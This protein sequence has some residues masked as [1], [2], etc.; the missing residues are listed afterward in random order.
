MTPD[1]DLPLDPS[2]RT[3]A[4]VAT[5]LVVLALLTPVG[6]AAVTY[7]GADLESGTVQQR[8]DGDTVVGIQGFHFKGQGSEK[9]PARLLSI[10]PNASFGW[11]FNGSRVGA[12][13][14]YD[15]DPLPD[16]DILVS[17]TN[18]EGTIALRIDRETRE[19]VWREEFPFE[20]THDVA[21]L[22]DGE[23]LI[24]NMRNHEDGVS[25]DRILVYNRTRGEVV[26]EWVVREHY[27]NSTAGGFNEDWTHVN[28]VDVVGD[29]LYLVSLRNFDQTI[30]VNRSTGEIELKLGDDGAHDVLYEQH[31]PD[32][33]EREDGT[34]VLLVADS[35]NDRVVEY[36]RDCPGIDGNG[37]VEAD[38][39]DCEWER[40]WEVGTGQLTWPRDADRLP[41]GNTLITDTLNHRVIEVTPTGEIV[42]EYFA[43]WGPYDAERI[44]TGS[45]SK[46]PTMSEREAFGRY[47][48]TNSAGLAPG[49]GDDR[50]F[51]QWLLATFDGTPVDGQVTWFAKRW[52][53]VVPWIT[54]IW[55]TGWNFAATALAALLLLGWGVTEAVYHRRRIR[56]RFGA[57][58]ARVR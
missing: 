40:V 58:A 33:L 3:L 43:Q 39:E 17:S 18:S 26:W 2:R 41:N 45:E 23:L 34:P 7:Q 32:Y 46:G 49:T 21:D 27:P 9:K 56:S 55:M 50:A 16:D 22:G 5:A 29:G 47:R 24:A 15:V 11:E 4:R 57:L 52:A 53:H 6:I 30:V 13:W 36:E 44:G 31:N 12:R 10:T 14:F 8:A 48:L 38:P 51:H 1:M 25:D 37:V 42:W 20:D 28:D 19:V 35:E 54:P